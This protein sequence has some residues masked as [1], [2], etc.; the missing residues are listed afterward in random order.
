MNKK[1]DYKNIASDY[2]NILKQYSWHAPQII[3]DALSD[4]IKVGAKLLDIGIGTGAS[5]Q[6][7]HKEGIDIYGLDNSE[8]LLAVCKAKNISENL[9]LYDLLEDEIPFSKLSFDYIICSG[10][11][12]FFSDLSLIFKKVNARLKKGG[13]FIFT[14]IDNTV[15]ESS[16]YEENVRGTTVYHHKMEYISKLMKEINY[17][18]LKDLDFLT[19]KDLKTKEQQ[20]IKLLMMRKE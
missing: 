11:L 18:E 14:I 4:Y 7:F 15:N 17:V 1:Y 3:F 5:S 12:H 16:I 6:L 19:L 2:D 10:V 20:E 13:L 8:E 9:L